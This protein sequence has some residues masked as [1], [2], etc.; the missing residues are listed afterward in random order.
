MRNKK[1]LDELFIEGQK[2]KTA[3]NRKYKKSFIKKFYRKTIR[4]LKRALYNGN[5]KVNV[6]APGFMADFGRSYLEEIA[7]IVGRFIRINNPAIQYEVSYG[8]KPT[9]SNFPTRTV[10]LQL[11]YGNKGNN[12]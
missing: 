10:F 8:D 7:N 1:S 5:T 2:R 4:E 9:L 3:I 11:K 12:V 6:W